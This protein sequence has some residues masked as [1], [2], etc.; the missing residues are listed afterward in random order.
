MDIE[1]DGHKLP[2]PF[3]V[4][5]QV[6]DLKWFGEQLLQRSASWLD[7]DMSWVATLM[8]PDDERIA[9]QAAEKRR[10]ED[11]IIAR[12]EAIKVARSQES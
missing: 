10:W 4:R 8:Q 6:S 9:S 5:G 7:T 12:A 1:I 2:S 11:S 3:T